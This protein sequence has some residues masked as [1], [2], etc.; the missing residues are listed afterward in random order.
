MFL[1]WQ[2]QFFCLPNVR[3]RTFDLTLNHKREITSQENYNNMSYK[4]AISSEQDAFITVFMT[5]IY[6]M[7]SFFCAPK[8]FY[9]KHKYKKLILLI[10]LF[11]FFL[12]IL[13]V[14]FWGQFHFFFSG[15]LY[16]HSFEYYN[17]PIHYISTLFTEREFAFRNT[18]C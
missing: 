8:Y 17:S 12:T 3:I 6:F 16:M 2:T 15:L 1:I 11:T 7:F 10:F 18:L 5:N 13:F 4:T 9:C 14:L